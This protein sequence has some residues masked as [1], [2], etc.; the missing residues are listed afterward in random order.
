MHCLHPNSEAPTCWRLQIKA[1]KVQEYFSFA[2]YGNRERARKAMLLREAQLMK[3]LKARQLRA[4]LPLNQMF[5]ELG[6]LRGLCLCNTTR[7]GVVAKMQ[8]TVQKK[9]VGASRKIH[10]ENM[11]E[12]F[13]ALAM[14]RLKKLGLQTT[15][16]LRRDLNASYRLFEQQYRRFI[17]SL[18]AQ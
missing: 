4:A 12:V 7:R 1:L 13:F 17:A 3:S 2:K 6:Q 5:D 9:Q 16:E 15:V 18:G 14:W 10:E 11:H 8:V